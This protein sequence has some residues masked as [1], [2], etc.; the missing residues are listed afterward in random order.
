MDGTAGF[1]ASNRSSSNPPQS[2]DS[3]LVM[4]YKEVK[5]ST[6]F[7]LQNLD[8]F[9]CSSTT[10]GGIAERRP[11]LDSARQRGTENTLEHF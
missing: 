5:S 9:A 8:I 2:S 7:Y 3:R 6:N 1:S 4:L 10:K 11:R